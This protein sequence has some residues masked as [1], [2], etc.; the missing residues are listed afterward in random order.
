MTAHVARRPEIPRLWRRAAPLAAW[1]LAVASS[2]EAWRT[3]AV[4][5]GLVG[6][7]LEPVWASTQGL[8]HGTSIYVGSSL[9]QFVYLPTTTAL[10][11]PFVGLGEHDAVRLILI[12]EMAALGAA[13]ALALVPLGRAWWR[14]A[15]PLCIALVMAADL[16][17]D[18]LFAGN[19]S[20]LVAPIAVLALL[21]FERDQW[22]AGCAL[23]VLSLMIKPLLAPLFLIPLL[24]RRWRDLAL[25]LLPG[26]VVVAILTV[27]FPGGKHITRVAK[28]LIHPP[29]LQ[30]HSPTIVH[31][32]SLAAVGAH[33]GVQGLFLV[34]RLVVL[35]ATVVALIAWKRRAE[36][37]GATAAV[38]AVLVLAGMLAGSLGER[39]YLFAV[40]PCV[41]LAVTLCR[42][43]K[44]ILVAAPA[45][46]L[47]F[48]PRAYLGGL[49]GSNNALQVRY[50][51]VTVLLFGAAFWVPTSS[52]LAARRRRTVMA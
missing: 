37:P 34:A 12:G 25:T 28:N 30:P 24:Q 11:L 22:R 50:M 4:P 47:F 52:W 20:M 15:A 43:R 32:I 27:T 46:L 21:S 29:S 51:L 41:L 40:T 35:T 42:G 16:T 31:N 1:L 26:A 5:A 18:T 7:D 45:A 9:G 44:A 10:L 13:F 14:W 8:L 38:G 17:R 39:N 6:L 3:A 23:L 36:A 48:A 19:L 33:H 2:F 49:G